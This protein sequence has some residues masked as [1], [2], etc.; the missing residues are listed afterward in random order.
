MTPY[1][2]TLIEK[3]MQLARNLAYQKKRL[4]PKFVDV[5][6]LVS[7]A[8]LGLCEAATRYDEAQGTAFITFAYRRVWGAIHDYLREQIVGKRDDPITVYSLDHEGEDETP[9][10]NSVADKELTS[11]DEVL[12]VLTSGL[13]EQSRETVRYYYFESYSMKEVGEKLGVS[14]SR[15]SQIIN[16]CKGA[17]RRKH[18][19]VE[20]CELLA[21]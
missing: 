21:A 2:D 7:A 13:S 4:L 19:P 20:L 11:D 1:Q 6:D 8:Y 15:V 12:E 14:E 16:S 9:L 5:E 17:I 10:K 3:H 18:T